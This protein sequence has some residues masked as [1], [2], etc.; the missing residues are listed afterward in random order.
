MEGKQFNDEVVREVF[1][2]IKSQHKYALS[3][4][5]TYVGATQP[6]DTDNYMFWID[7][8]STPV[9][10][11]RNKIG[12]SV[13]YVT[14]S[15]GGSGGGSTNNAILTV[16]NK[17]GWLAKTVAFGA[18]CDIVIEWSSIEDEIPTGNGTVT[19]IV[20]DVI[21]AV[22][23]EK[24]GSITI[25][26]DNY[27]LMGKN[28][29]K[30]AISDLYG[31]T[32]EINFNVTCVKVS[33]ESYFDAN[34][35]YTGNIAYSYTPTGAIEKTVYFLI[36]GEKIDERVVT[37]SG[38]EQPFTI[39]AQ[40]HGSHTFEVYFVGN[41]DGQPVESNHLY[42][43]LICARGESTP[44]IA[45]PFR[46]ESVKQFSTLTIPY[47]VYDPQLYNSEIVLKVNGEDL[48]TL[49]VDRTPQTWRYKAE[50]VGNI[51]LEIVCGDVKKEFTFEVTE[52]NIDVYAESNNLELY[53][54]SKGRSNNEENPLDWSFGDVKA[55]LT[56]FNLTTDGWQPDDNGDT[57]FRVTGDARAFIPFQIFEN[58]FRTSGKTIEIEFATRDVLNYD[59]VIMSAMSGGRGIQFTAQKAY[60]AFEGGEIFTQYK[61]NEHIR[62][63]FT[64]EKRAENR[65]V[66]I[67][68]N[69]VM[70]GVVQYSEDTDFSQAE[71]V[72]ISIGSSECTTD[73]YC[74]RVYSNNLSQYQILDNWIAD[75]QDIEELIQRYNRNNIFDEYGNVTVDKLPSTLPYL[76]LEAE[77]Y[78]YLPQFKGDKERP[79][80][81]KYVDPMN[82]GRCFT[83]NQAQIDV[84][85]TS[86]QYYSR[87]N[88]K[89]KFKN[90]FIIDGVNYA[91]YQLRNTSVPTNTFTFKA[92]VA[93]S[94]GAN[95]VEL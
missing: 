71:P 17:S 91:N 64:V 55:E 58:D 32:R 87:K 4:A 24:Q 65:L 27:L 57:V 46:I 22:Y 83:F 81:G 2:L 41:I 72:G 53:L 50:E 44:I 30:V 10:K 68:I 47:I 18:E 13:A 79:V 36:D 95:N 9:L 15:G 56:G 33:L 26:I 75:T 66:R 73:I 63:A 5:H 90:G 85:G 70:S 48:T 19:I 43:D 7:T 69:G 31:N 14:L 59:S 3:F 60:M 29:V 35:A 61:E 76:V 74:I 39:P 88:Y 20:D 34:I 45:S 86:S 40:P 89:I 52:N 78:A 51:K 93:S 1:E 21:K 77:D 54:T 49:T 12:D 38:R 92:D 16:T 42:Y 84:Q 62:I 8:T 80:N 67:Y 94:E 23:E 37:A 82:A 6:T 11:F 28:S 25:N